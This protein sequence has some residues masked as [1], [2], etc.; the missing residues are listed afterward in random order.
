MAT[1]VMVIQL[2]VCIHQLTDTLFSGCF[3]CPSYIQSHKERDQQEC[4]QQ[5]A[6]LSLSGSFL[7][8]SCLWT[9]VH[10]AHSWKVDTGVRGVQL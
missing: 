8:P 1:Y 9:T 6:S 4:M 10:L 2:C 3:L 5:K 7:V